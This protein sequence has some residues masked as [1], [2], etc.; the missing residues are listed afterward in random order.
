MHWTILE[1]EGQLTDILA[2]NNPCLIFKHSTRC[3]VSSMAKRNIT[4]DADAIPSDVPVYYLDLIKYR[5]ISNEIARIWGVR[6]ESPQV[7][8]V[9]GKVCL[10]HASH[11]DI[12]I[13]EAM[14]NLAQG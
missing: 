14:A 3:P 13:A 6:H 12:D 4:L 8:L 5:D 2:S 9:Q 11:S 10:Y 7:L 1:T